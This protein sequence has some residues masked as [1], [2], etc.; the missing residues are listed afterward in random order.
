MSDLEIITKSR[1]Q[2]FALCQRHHEYVYGLGYRSLAPR[3]LA[4]F[5]SLFHAGL[6]A[7]FQAYKDG[8]QLLALANA[9]AAMAK[10]RTDVAPTMPVDN[11][12]KA[13]L[14]MQAYDVRWAPSI[15]KLLR[16]IV[17]QTV[18]YGEHKS[19]GADISQG[20]DYWSRLR[21]D[22]QVS[23]YHMGCLELGYQPAGCLYDVAARPA[24]RMLKATPE[25]ARKY[26]KAGALY[27][28][29]RAADETAEEYRERMAGAILADP[30][31]YFA[32]REIVRLESE[33]TDSLADVTETAL[34]IRSGTQT[35]VAPRNPA[36]CYWYGRPCD[37]TEVCE[38]L[39]RLDDPTRF[40]KLDNVHP[41]LN[42]KETA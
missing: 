19:T 37:F 5:G 27:A 13:E 12:I 40:L 29:Q 17:D 20:S 26:T 6:D 23:L 7:W 33:I 14:L 8:A 22:P 16:R 42:L 30:D 41:E 10:Y 28:N 24:Q 9:L 32:R 3:E 2:S 34:Q 36:A 38:G 25:A 4:D 11:F 31:A 21:M 18:W 1:L 39:A 15:D 35:G